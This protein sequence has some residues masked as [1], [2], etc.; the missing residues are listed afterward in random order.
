M[1]LEDDLLVADFGQCFE[2]MRHYDEAFRQ[3]LE[4]AVT[5][6]VAVLTACAFLVGNYHFSAEVLAG[7]AVIL[8]L[9]SLAGMLLVSSLLRH[10]AY[11][12]RV[13]RY[14][15]EI[16]GYYLGKSNA[17]VANLAGMYTDPAFPAAWSPGSTQCFQMYLLIACLAALFGLGCAAAA[18]GSEQQ[19]TAHVPWGAALGGFA[20]FALANLAR[21][22]HYLKKADRWAPGG[23]P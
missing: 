22:L 5:G 17:V 3:T 7:L 6:V 13:C 23:R 19:P 8:L 9:S 1:A 20:V 11:F 21:M 14:V 18:A 4:F 2:Q 10:R 15:N 12:T 16:R